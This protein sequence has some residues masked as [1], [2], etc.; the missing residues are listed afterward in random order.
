MAK[1]LTSVFGTPFNNSGGADNIAGSLETDTAGTQVGAQNSLNRLPVIILGKTLAFKGEM[2]ADEELMLL[3]RVEG[4]IQ[5]TSVLT[6]GVSG[7]VMG[8]IRAKVL[9][10]KGTV[11]G[12]IMASESVTIA[13]TAIVTGDI[14]APRV[15]IVD[16]AQF[17]GTVEMPAPPA[18]PVVQAP[19]ATAAP[20]R[21]QDVG[22]LLGE[23]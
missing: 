1:K 2:H 20:L 11:E 5:H 3:G 12:D 13:P 6:V 9:T 15:C 4:S 8:N 21:E 18:Q 14:T 22:A 19:A 7:T 17:N 16:G 23:Q 10:V